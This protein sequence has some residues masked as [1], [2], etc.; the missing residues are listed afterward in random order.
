MQTNNLYM[1]ASVNNDKQCNYVKPFHYSD[2]ETEYNTSLGKVN[3]PEDINTVKQAFLKINNTA[4]GTITQCCNPELDETNVTT[5]L[6]TQY[7]TK[8]PAVRDIIKNGVLDAIEVSTV[9]QNMAQNG[10]K[11]LSPYYLC[12]LSK[13][14]LKATSVPN[15]FR[16]ATLLNDCYSKSCSADTVTLAHLFNST[17]V[18]TSYTYYD[19]AKVAQSIQEG[20]AAGLEKYLRKYN[21]VNVYLTHDDYE[22]TLLHLAARN[23]SSPKVLAM[24]L[25]VKPNLEVRNAEGDKPLHVACRYGNMPVIEQL[26]KLGA[27]VNP[28]NNKGETPVMLAVGY[29]NPKD[30]DVNGI[31]LRYL[32]NN[33][34]N[35][36]DQDNKGNTI[37]HHIIKHTPDTP[38]KTKLVR[39]IVDHG[40]SA[41]TK[42]TAGLTALELTAD[43][44]DKLVPTTTKAPGATPAATRSPYFAEPVIPY[45]TNSPFPIKTINYDTLGKTKQTLTE[46]NIKPTKSS[47]TTTSAQTKTIN[48]APTTTTTTK[49]MAGSNAYSSDMQRFQK[50]LSGTSPTATVASLITNPSLTKAATTTTQAAA[51][52][53]QAAATTPSQ[54]FKNIE[55]FQ[56]NNQDYDAMIP[57]EKELLQIQTLLFNDILKSNPDKYNKYINV[58]EVPRGAPVEVLDYMCTGGNDSVT[59]TEDRETCEAMGGQLIK[60]KNPT[61]LVKLELLPDSER[62][63]EAEEEDELYYPKY[64]ESMPERPLPS[65]ETESMATTTT[66]KAIKKTSQKANNKKVTTA[67]K[68]TVKTNEMFTDFSETYISRDAEI[69]QPFDANG[70]SEGGNL[71]DN[72][73]IYNQVPAFANNGNNL[74]KPNMVPVDL[75]HPKIPNGQYLIQETVKAGI[76]S[77]RISAEEGGQLVK[78]VKVLSSNLPL[79]ITLILLFIMLGMV[80]YIWLKK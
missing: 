74:A 68:P 60:I 42:N 54:P 80:M 12:K 1:V 50:W 66:Q 64:P 29:D 8:F 25:A 18:D 4:N 33:G 7:R 44:L 30:R 15:V 19:D 38:E 21:K 45:K 34:A 39:F 73:Q 49:Y 5:E 75:E 13:S 32:Y 17:R 22:N 9:A 47:T 52:T 43:L 10:W 48:T 71:T 56:V 76:N 63:I 59:G 16:T 23:K 55:P 58:S 40:V 77:E 67:T 37:L 11:V 14:E 20:D 27:E 70:L 3:T 36:F 31:M 2:I 35:L 57:R 72:L 78:K 62:M 65:L 26:V 51:T 79:F 46:K 24:L 6:L 61:T 53:T 28:K 41:E 69:A